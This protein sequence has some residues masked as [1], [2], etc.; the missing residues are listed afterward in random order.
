MDFSNLKKDNYLYSYQNR[1]ALL[2][3]KD[4]TP[5]DFIKEFIGLRSKLYLIKNYF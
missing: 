4:E 1:K 3:F 2:Y 5:S